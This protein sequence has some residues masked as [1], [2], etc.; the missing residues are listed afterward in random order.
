[1]HRAKACCAGGAPDQLLAALERAEEEE[2]RRQGQQGSKRARLMRRLESGGGGGGNGGGGQPADLPMAVH[3]AACRQLAAVLGANPALAACVGGREEGIAAALVRGLAGGR[4]SKPVLQ[5]LAA[6]LALQ[7]RRAA[8]AHEVPA[9][10]AALHAATGAA[11]GCAGTPP[12]EGQAAAALQLEA[13]AAG[14]AAGAAGTAH[15][16]P[17]LPLTAERLRARVAEAARLA[18]LATRGDDAQRVGAAVGA[19]RR[20]QD[21]PVTAQLL[22]HSGAGKH[23]RRL[24]KHGV[25]AVAAAAAAA[26]RAWRARLA[27]EQQ[28]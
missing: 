21:A 27:G 22:Q 6:N 19:L 2:E 1:M 7:L 4:P 23:V 11:E 20:L 3:Q 14:P 24:G 10:Q 5:S 28:G 13:A 16:G 15:T 18:G 17:G 26:E 25:P 9:L 12:G 8:A